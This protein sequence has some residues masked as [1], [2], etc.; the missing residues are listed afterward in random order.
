VGEVVLVHSDVVSGAW[1]LQ[2]DPTRFARHYGDIGALLGLGEVLQVLEDSSVRGAIDADVRRISARWY[3]EPEPCPKRGYADSPAF[4]PD[5]E[6]G[7]FLEST[8][9]ETVERLWDPDRRPTLEGVLATVA[10]S[11]PLLDPT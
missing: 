2:A 1:R 8:F 11:R 3:R 4:N 6:F 9:G 10:A 7:R 5:E